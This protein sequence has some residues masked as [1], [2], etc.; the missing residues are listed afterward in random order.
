MEANKFKDL[1]PIMK[2]KYSRLK[3]KLKKKGECGCNKCPA[4]MDKK[5]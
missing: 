1:K 2:Q 4:C 3:S 5:K